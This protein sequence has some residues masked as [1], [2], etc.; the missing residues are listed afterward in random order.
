MAELG[1]LLRKDVGE[2]GD[3]AVRSHG[4]HRGDHSVLAGPQAEV[5]SGVGQGLDYLLHVAVGFL[6]AHDVGVLAQRGV[7]L[8]LY[9]HAGASGHV[10]E[11]LRHGAAVR[12]GCVHRDESRLG[13]L[14][15][16]GRYQESGVVAHVVS[17][18]RELYRVCGV[19][20]SCACDHRY[21]VAGELHGLFEDLAVLLVREGGAFARG[22]ADEEGVYSFVYLPVDEPLKCVVIYAVRVHGCYERGACSSEN[23]LF[24]LSFSFSFRKGGSKKT[25]RAFCPADA[26]CSN[27]AL[28]CART[29]VTALRLSDSQPDL[30]RLPRCAPAWRTFGGSPFCAARSLRGSFMRRA[31]PDEPRLY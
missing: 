10:V 26:N 13:G 2:H 6:D 4:E 30:I 23:Y 22:A 18:L 15:V 9:V 7:G 29:I 14:V 24:H 1:G 12:D 16:V 28:L 8:R 25:S 19:V 3:D 5:V 27:D 21:S 31:T 20:G 11:Y 17:Y